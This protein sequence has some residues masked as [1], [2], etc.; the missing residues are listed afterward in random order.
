MIFQQL[1]FIPAAVIL[2]CC[3]YLLVSRTWRHSLLALS[4]MYIGI[5][6]IVALL[7]PVGLAVVKLVVGWMAGA[8][9]GATAQNTPVNDKQPELR[10]VR[11]FRLTV[12]LVVL[13]VVISALPS[14]TEWIP[15]DRTILA[16]A[17]IL[18]GMGILQ[19]GIV[20]D[21]FHIFLGLLM[22]LAGFE[23]VY[24]SQ[25]SSVLVAGLLA[26]INLG[27]SLTGAYLISAPSETVKE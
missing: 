7:W 14:L 15:I 16:S 5:F 3:L 13:I 17:M 2:G 19:L 21:P 22:C 8:V 10:T 26:V 25:E 23:I 20:A 6:W 1:S 12:G 11:L 24:A 18:I 27:L 9:L 4:V